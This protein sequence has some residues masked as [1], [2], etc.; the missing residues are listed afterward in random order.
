MVIRTNGRRGA[1]AVQVAFCLV[2]LLGVAALCMDGG[3]LFDQRRYAQ[4]VADSAALAAAASLY[5]NYLTNNGADPSGT[6]KAAALAFAAA[7]GCTNNGTTSVVMVNIPP[8]QST[9]FK[10]KPGYAEVI[11]QVNVTRS[12]SGIFGSGTLP[13]SAISVARGL[14][15][16]SL[17]SA[18]LIALSPTGTGIS[19]TGNVSLDVTGSVIV[20]SNSSSAISATGNVSLTA[21]DGYYV[22][23]N[24]SET[25]NISVSG[26][27]NTGAVATPDPLAYLPAPDASSLSIQSSKQLQITGNTTTTLQPGVY[28]GGISVTG[29]GSLTLE[30]GIYYLE[31]GGLSMTGNVSLTGSGVTIYNGPSNPADPVASTVGSISLTGNAAVNLSP[32]T[33]GMYQGL[34]I[35][36][37]Q[38]ATAPLTITGNGNMKI[39]GTIYAEHGSA[40]LTGNSDTIGSQVIADS[41]TI[42]GNG[43]VKIAYSS[44]STA[45]N[46]IVGLVQ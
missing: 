32:P 35:F 36:Q 41:L 9:L 15:S 45:M 30:P 5:T 23:G 10:S 4:D 27:M 11:V 19:A 37:E 24:A 8:L 17:T 20:D 42:T 34:T 40:S 3:L 16:P 44:T 43:A 28:V 21:S 26:T 29:N 12:F 7:N 31:G 6:A 2:P 38:A 1:V 25:G 33:T 39:S 22:T 14:W 18:A 13:V 46:R